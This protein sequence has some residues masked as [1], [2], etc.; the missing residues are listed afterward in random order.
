LAN[1]VLER[2]FAH[3]KNNLDLFGAMQ[4]GKIVVINTAKD[5]LKTEGQ[6]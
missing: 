2:M 1:P 6:R 4:D 3:P 5:L